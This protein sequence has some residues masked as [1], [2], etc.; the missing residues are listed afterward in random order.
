MSGKFDSSLITQIQQANDIVDVVSEHLSLSRKGKEMVG[1]C[2]F[3]D[4]KSPSL[5]VSPAKQIFKCFACGAG[6]DVVKF[7][8][9]RESLSFP[10]ALERLAKRAGIVIKQF[11]RRSEQHDKTVADKQKIEKLNGWAL[12]FWQ[13]NLKNTD[14]GKSAREYIAKRK[15]SSE[16][17]EKWQ[18]GFA[19][20]AWDALLK[21]AR[22]AGFS[23]ADLEAAGLVAKSPQNSYYDKFR[24]RL[25][26]PIADTSGRI[27]GFGGRTLGN[28]P[29][30]YMNSPATVL[31]DKSFALY[32]LNNAR[33]SIVSTGTAV[34]V[35]GYTD[36]MMAHQFGCSNAVATLG[37]SFTDGHARILKRFAKTVVLVFDGDVAGSAAAGRALQICLANAVDIKIAFVPSGS[38]PC[39]FVLEKGA[40]AFNGLIAEAVDVMEFAWA[41]LQEQFDKSQS[42]TD[43]KD[44][45]V[46]FI[47]TVGTGLASGKIDAI[48]KGLIINRLSKLTAVSPEQINRMLCKGAGKSAANNSAVSNLGNAKSVGT[49]MQNFARQAQTQIIEVLLNHPALLRNA[50]GK[51]AE[52]DF[53]DDG[54]R[55]IWRLLNEADFDPD[56][57]HL[58][59]L[60]A[61]VESVELSARIT[62]LE[63]SGR[64]LGNHLKR[65]K[66]A[67]EAIKEYS[68]L[69]KKRQLHESLKNSDDEAELLKRVC[70]IAKK[71]SRRNPGFMSN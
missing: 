67:V 37:T 5:N 28:D 65:F 1:L 3:H 16:S 71:P 15:I 40:D 35:E 47:E 39:D 54:L 18:L 68:V 6:G 63:E 43:R 32:G 8:Q 10:Q 12:R 22:K 48:S 62:T 50:S 14:L 19:P 69:Q 2:P 13:T 34:V 11:E 61:G 30:K 66:A 26:F 60:L 64:K 23:E 9:M 55:Q 25:M 45:A 33:H 29:A 56:D 27:V 53:T 7:V 4:D 21:G 70:D 58:P 24:N 59:S 46:R 42:I 17:A 20:D 38:D 31:F 57:F 41:R 44:A 52:E 36:V 49:D 51:L